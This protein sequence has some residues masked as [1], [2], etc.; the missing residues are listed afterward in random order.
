MGFNP[1]AMGVLES[2]GGHAAGGRSGRNVSGRTAVVTTPIPRP[3]RTRAG[4][5]LAALHCRAWP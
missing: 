1:A 2:G 4:S 3:A 5:G